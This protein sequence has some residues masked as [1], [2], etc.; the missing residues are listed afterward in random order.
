MNIKSKLF[1]K[2][3]ICRKGNFYE[4]VGTEIKKSYHVKL[5]TLGRPSKFYSKLDLRNLKC[6]E[7]I[8]ISCYLFIGFSC[9]KVKMKTIQFI[10]I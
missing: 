10:E 8:L 2:H 5:I 1:E 9:Y 4:I 6:M 3:I 7:I